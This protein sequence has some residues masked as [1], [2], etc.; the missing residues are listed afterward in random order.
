MTRVGKCGEE[1]QKPK[2]EELGGKTLFCFFKESC[3][4][5]GLFLPATC[6]QQCSGLKQHKLVI[7]RFWGDQKSRWTSVG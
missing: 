5:L 6:Y 3:T 2:P 1:R 4:A 7:L